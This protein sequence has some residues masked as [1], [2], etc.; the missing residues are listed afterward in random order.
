MT[1]K[2][3]SL[4][5]RLLALAFALVL[6]VP[7]A[8]AVPAKPGMTRLLTLKDGRKVSA[9]LQGDEF[10]SYYLGAD[11]R[12]YVRCAADTLYEET[13]AAAF[14]KLEARTETRR[15]QAAGRRQSRLKAARRN[16]IGGAH[17]LYEGKRRC[18]IV[19]VEF[20]DKR[21]KAGH[22]RTFYE[23]IANERHFTSPLGFKGSL[24]D[25]FLDQ[26]HGR[27][28]LDFDVAGPVLMPRGYAYYGANS[29]DS[30]GVRVGQMIATALQSIDATTDFSAYDWGGDGWVDQIYFL[31]AGMGEAAGGD[32]D[33]IWPHEFQLE[34]SDLGR[35]LQFDGVGVNTY[36][37]GCEIT[38]DYVVNKFTGQ[39]TRVERTDGI[40]TICHE[41]SHCLGLP[42][43][44]D[45]RG[46][47]YYGMATWDLMAQG[48]Y[49]GNSFVPS[50]Y[51]GYERIYCGWTEPV[52]LD[53]P[54]SVRRMPSS[55]L[56]GRPFIVR[57]TA[58][59][60]EYYLLE[61][62]QMT[63]WDAAQYGRG[64]L[65]THVDYDPLLWAYNSLNSDMDYSNLKN[66]HPRM[67]VIPADNNFTLSAQGIAGDTYPYGSA[68][69]L[70]DETVPA[71]RL[72]NAGPDG[73]FLMH[74]PITNIR[75]EADGTLS[76]DFMG[77]S[78]DHVV[79]GISGI[80]AERKA[81]QAVY[82]LGGRAVTVPFGRLPRGI[83]IAGGRKVLR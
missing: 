45:T 35:S 69:A 71:A 68:D 7:Q 55:S 32:E 4:L 72:Y 36:A 18:L 40:G 31:Y 1:L 25:Y 67:T 30:H 23:R 5:Y 41:F 59:P 28:E 65:V 29:A 20:Q 63:G 80:T 27:F 15:R 77:G 37:C 3:T 19:L 58:H 34:Y 82:D 66:D 2:S 70:T 46:G 53:R 47:K 12:R 76:F 73:E 52:V 21:F 39:T 54:T 42:D 64:L 56:Y 61:N 38:V 24:K 44:Y 11:G 9:T 13:T 16:A 79:D 48:N 17:T 49:N 43:T 14:T 6:Q 51:T 60:D 22:D 62:R 50:N 57:N 10:L 78:V 74:A 83:Y 33:T 8:G 81:P 75:Q 26:S